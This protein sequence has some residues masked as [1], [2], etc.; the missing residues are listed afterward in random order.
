MTVNVHERY[1][2]NVSGKYT[3]YRNDSAR[4][5]VDI[6]TRVSRRDQMTTDHRMVSG[7]VTLGIMADV[8]YRP[9]T[10]SIMAGQI[11]EALDHV[12]KY[13]PG[14]NR[15]KVR[16]LAAIWDRWHFNDMHAGCIHQADNA[17]PDSPP[18]QV[19]LYSWGHAWLAEEIPSSVLDELDEMFKED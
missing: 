13:A 6:R 10:D 2:G 3:G 14:W 16:R 19:T 18:C 12:V 11:R 15:A 8:R 4:L 1:I 17:G 7:L 5:Y 9:E